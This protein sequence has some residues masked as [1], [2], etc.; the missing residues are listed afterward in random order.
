MSID[1]WLKQARPWLA[2]LAWALVPWVQ[3]QSEAANGADVA[4]RRAEAPVPEGQTAAETR[5][6]YLEKTD[7]A[8]RT[9]DR[10]LLE[11][12]LREAMAAL[13]QDPR[14]PNDL[15]LML[16][17]AGR[18]AEALALIDQAIAR[19]QR[20]VER[21]FY[22]S[23]RLSIAARRT[24]E[25]LQQ[26]SLDLRQQAEQLLPAVR[27]AVER[28]ALLRAIGATHSRE[29]DALTRRGRFHDALLARERGESSYRRAMEQVAQMPPPQDSLRVITATG[30]A[31]TQRDLAGSYIRLGQHA[32]AE[33]TIE[34]M[35]ELVRSQGLSAAFV[36]SVHRLVANLRLR[37]GE[38]EAAERQLRESQ[39][40]L[41]QLRFPA[42]HPFQTDRRRDLML[43]Q[44][45]LGRHEAALR[46]LEALDEA[47]RRDGVV[48]RGRYT[49]ERG[50]VLMGNGRGAEA[51]REFAALAQGNRK[52][53]G[54]DHYYT[55][56]AQ[57]L[58]G[59][60]LWTQSGDPGLKVRAL[61]LLERAVPA[62]M[63]PAH[64]DYHDDVNARRQLRT[65]LFSA[66]LD[67]LVGQ[68]GDRAVAAF[69]IADRVL[70]GATGQAMTDAAV[71]A[72]AAQ[73]GLAERVRREQDTRLLVQSLTEELRQADAAGDGVRRGEGG[74]P[75]DVEADAQSL[76]QRLSE[77][78][79]DLQAAREELRQAFPEFDRLL[80]PALP[81]AAEV[82]RALAPDEA[83]LLALPTER[84]LML[85]LLT[86]DQ[87]PRVVSVE[88]PRSELAAWV[89][90]LRDG[91]DF[92]RAGG[93]RPSFDAALAHRLYQAVLEPVAAGLKGRRHLIVA[94]TGPLAALPFAALPTAPPGAGEPAWLARQL[95]LSQVP[96][97]TAW[98][99]LRQLPAAR[100]APEP[101]LAWADPAYPR[102]GSV[103]PGSRRTGASLPPLPETRDEA[104]AIAG[105]LRARPERDLLLGPQAT[106]ESVL[107]ASRNGELARRRVVVFATHGLTAGDLP[108][109]SQPALALAPPGGSG[110]ALAG[111]LGLDDILSLK[112]NADWV[113]LSACNTAAGDGQ[114]EEALSGLARG[115]LYAG[116]RSLLVTHWAVETES[117]KRLTTRTFAHRAA[118]PQ[119]AKAESLRQAM[120]ELMAEPRY[121]HPAYWAPFALVGEGGR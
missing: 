92:E 4:R 93:R 18:H 73:P 31:A 117:A 89:Q 58:Q 96:S 30:L 84:A 86:A 90:Q 11:R 14:W 23:N 61:P 50:L 68:G 80:R 35:S 70:A 10:E 49:F 121:A 44:W 5:R 28:V 106:R 51:A 1:R 95:A 34:A 67:A 85:W 71:R 2:A 33:R 21:L 54:A 20:P 59:A 72:A 60:A 45:A 109:L 6:L 87:P 79:T 81:T 88:R 65:L 75:G 97:V 99:A 22:Q 78:E 101:L 46:E 62:M 66:Y 114:A 25:Q 107:A 104:M 32:K 83:L 63:A 27:T 47:L 105:A 15:A 100:P 13:P 120:L 38:F 26:Q 119:S 74:E 76:R 94:T 24:P 36:A 112:L 102:P 43:V 116:S 55:W 40:V 29:A 64:A 115:F 16:R 52:D 8:R 17:D 9:G 91:L 103:A 7:A 113:V 77:A 57:A 3:A 42:S 82:G 48:G 41:D 19:T 69:G 39:R 110:D 118:Q 12:S 98:L 37:R 53:Y 56:Q 108:G 111:L